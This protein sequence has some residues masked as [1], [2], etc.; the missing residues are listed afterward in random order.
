MEGE[1]DQH[2]E[3]AAVLEEVHVVEHE[4]DGR[5]PLGER[6]AEPRKAACPDRVAGSG[7]RLEDRR[8]ER[9][10]AVQGLG[11]VREQHDGIVVPVVE[12]DPREVA[13]V[14]RRPLSE[15]GRLPVSR[16]SDDADESSLA[17]A[18][19]AV[20]EPTFARRHRGRGIG[21]SSFERRTSNALGIDPHGRSRSW[22]LGY[23]RPAA[24][25]SSVL[26]PRI[27]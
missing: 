16:R 20:D 2:V 18:R 22:P 5:I 6:Y 10:V 14:S 7:E 9:V 27:P 8:I 24:R 13:R 12:R 1:R 26:T 21:A 17:R 19:E 15:H 3:A 25:L 23:T 4:H 11:D